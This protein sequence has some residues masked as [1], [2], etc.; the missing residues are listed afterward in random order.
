MTVHIPA[1]PGGLIAS[2]FQRG[3]ELALGFDVVGPLAM[4]N[5][6]SVRKDGHMS[7]IG[8]S[9]DRLF[10]K[11]TQNMIPRNVRF[12]DVR[13]ISRGNADAIIGLRLKLSTPLPI[14]PT[15]TMPLPFTSQVSR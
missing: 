3:C 13:S 10:H 9:K 6:V 2:F 7:A 8:A 5:V 1:F 12:L 4:N 11:L 14:I 15:A